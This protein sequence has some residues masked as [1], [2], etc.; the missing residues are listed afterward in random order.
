[1]TTENTNSREREIVVL[2]DIDNASPEKIREIMAHIATY[3]HINVKKAFGDWAKS[4]QWQKVLDPLA[5]QPVQQYSYVPGKN[6][7][8]ITMVIEAMDL[9]HKNKFDT[10]VLVSS[11]SDFTALAM[12]LKED[13]IYVIGVGEKKTPIA[14]IKACEDFVYTEKL[15]TEDIPE[16]SSEGKHPLPSKK[17]G[18]GEM[19]PEDIPENS[20]EGKH[21]LPSKKAGS[22][23]M[24]PEPEKSI[25]YLLKLLNIACE[26]Y[27]DDDGWTFVSKAGNYL[28]ARIDRYDIYNYKFKKLIDLIKDK[29][30]LYEV[31]N[32]EKNPSKPSA[33]KYK[34]KKPDM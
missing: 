20:S 4:K 29:K 2:I 33:Y 12:R 5:I 17:A 22:D 14:F 21:P 1:M 6:S 7:T 15:E 8:D 13:K 9:L 32:V 31:K 18:S 19:E 24:E 11:D 10:F 28:T 30:D 3:G 26:R 34:K 23:E 25:E 27:A 16:N